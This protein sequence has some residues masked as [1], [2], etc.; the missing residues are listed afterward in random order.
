MRNWLRRLRG[1]V[2]TA[3]TWALAW[4]PAGALWSVMPWVSPPNLVVTAVFVV[5]FATMGLVAGGAFSVVLSLTDGRRRFDELSLPRVAAWGALGG[6]V[7]TAFMGTVFTYVV[8]LLG[9][10]GGGF[11]LASLIFG[12]VTTLL[13]AGSAA[14]SLVIARRHDDLELLEAGREALGLTEA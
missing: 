11:S 13:C 12:G 6:V 3:V 4:A 8:G 5:Q 14:G 2:G 1:V 10:A 7:M 9:F